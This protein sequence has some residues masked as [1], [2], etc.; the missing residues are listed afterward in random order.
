MLV[1]KLTDGISLLTGVRSTLTVSVLRGDVAFWIGSGIS[2]AK[3]PDVPTLVSRTLD[4]LHGQ[5]DA[6]NANCPYKKALSDILV[7]SSTDDLRAGT[8]PAGWDPARKAELIRQLSEKYADVLE[9]DVRLASGTQLITWDLLKLQDIYSN[10]TVTPDAEHRLIALLIEEGI[11][12][13]MVTTNWDPLIEV[14]HAQCRGP[15]PANLQIV[16]ASG[17]WPRNG[18]S[19]RLIKIHG[20]ARKSQSDEARYRQYLIATHGD[21]HRWKEDKLFE[22]ARTGFRQIFRERTAFFVGLSAQ[23]WNIQGEF[24]A[25]AFGQDFF[26]ASPPKVFFAEPQIKNSQRVVL[27]AV[28]GNEAYNGDPAAIDEAALVPAFA[29]TLFGSLYLVTIERKVNTILQK[30]D[31]AF[32]PEYDQLMANA[33]TQVKAEWLTRYDGMADEASRWS[34]VAEEVSYFVSRT[35]CLFRN[36]TV[37]GNRN[38]YEPITDRHLASM[39]NTINDSYLLKWLMLALSL[40]REGSNRGHWNLAF[41]TAY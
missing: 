38:E 31:P 23:D 37:A 6:T 15:K 27:R 11:I 41:P 12:G 30:A 7:L 21:L 17:E 18:A 39:E 5:I 22:P 35:L 25:T 8:N 36:W 34:A 3:F 29:K 9:Q 14:A 4:M 1:S 28:Y 13:E 2:R 32:T 16:V 10:T 33:V 26:P 24:A 40:L 20:C 19:A